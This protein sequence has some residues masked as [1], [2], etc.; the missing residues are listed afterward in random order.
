MTL[1]LTDS[2]S[3]NN[4][5]TYVGFHELL[6]SVYDM[7]STRGRLRRLVIGSVGIG[8]Y[9]E[10]PMCSF[11]LIIFVRLRDADGCRI[12]PG[13]R[14]GDNIM[15]WRFVSSRKSDRRRTQRTTL[16]SIAAGILDFNVD[17]WWIFLNQSLN[18]GGG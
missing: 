15:Y 3:I 7:S 6:S 11:D 4:V 18:V 12:M 14:E 8:A 17:D 2:W 5:S 13:E 9:R 16:M 10:I 1:Y